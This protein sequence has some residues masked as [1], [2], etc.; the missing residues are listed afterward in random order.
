MKLIV[1]ENYDE[2]SQKAAEIITEIIQK[3][4][5]TKLGLATGSTPT[6]LYDKLIENYKEGKLDFS[7][8]STVNLDEYIGI[9][10]NDPN[11]YHQFMNDHL[12][13]KVNID[14]KN[15]HVPEIYKSL[16]ET[17][18]KY[19][20]LL[21][22]FGK[23]D[24]QVLGIG[25]N[26]HIAFNEPASKLNIHTSIIDLDEN[27]INANSRFFKSIDEVPKKAISMGMADI[28]DSETLIVL[29]SGK[30]KQKTIE[31]FLNMDKVDPMF[32][33]SF[34]NLHPNCYLII[35]KEAYGEEK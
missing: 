11:S 33:M 20:Q 24:V 19:D 34:I 13:D 16:E 32:P 7:Q 25:E 1:C 27:T 2:M 8:V 23:R 28:F 30:K 22:D 29:A 21:K 31:K 35:D 18:K 12:F 26:G 3:N 9:D 4:P 6:G 10:Y 5:K 14:K 15:T 17:T